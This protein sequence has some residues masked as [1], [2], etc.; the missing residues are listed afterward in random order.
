MILSNLLNDRV[1][2]HHYQYDARLVPLLDF[3]LEQLDLPELQT[4]IRE[5]VVTERPRRPQTPELLQR[6]QRALTPCRHQDWLARRGMSA[7][8][9]YALD[10]RRLG[11]QDLLDLHILPDD[12]ILELHGERPV[13]GPVF[14][15]WRHGEL[16][17]VCVRNASTDRDFARDAKYT[18][19]NYG[20]FLEGYDLYEHHDRVILTE[21]V[22]D[23]LALR[24]HGY[25]AIA[26]GTC[27]PTS[28]QLACLT[29]KFKTLAVCFD[30]D[31]HGHYGAYAVSRLLRVQALLTDQKDAACCVERGLPLRLRPVSREELRQMLLGEIAE[32][33]QMII[34]G[35]VPQRPLPYN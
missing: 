7:E 26:L 14:L 20:W 22:F 5:M 1:C 28:Q 30:N 34:E 17:G 27:S 31:L 16:A 3:Q 18:F 29:A 11:R 23:A 6:L 12:H 15:D 33:N 13:D 24:Q 25:N 4:P 2:P 32:Y 19:S 35:G 10:H 21:G 9:I 8:D